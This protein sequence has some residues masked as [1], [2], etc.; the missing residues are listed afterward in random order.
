LGDVEIQNL[1]LYLIPYHLCIL[2]FERDCS[3]EHKTKLA[4]NKEEDFSLIISLKISR[5]GR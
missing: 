2:Q 1:I 4:Q 3:G 5:V